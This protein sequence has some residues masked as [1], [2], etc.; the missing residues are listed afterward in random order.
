MDFNGIDYLV[1]SDYYSRWIEID[2][3]SSTTSA[4]IIDK[5]SVYLSREGILLKIRTDNYPTFHVKSNEVIV[6]ENGYSALNIKSDLPKSQ[7]PC[8]ENR[9]HRKKYNLEVSKHKNATSTRSRVPEHAVYGFRSSV[10]L[11][12][13]RQLR[14]ISPCTTKHIKPKTVSSAELHKTRLR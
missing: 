3:M 13:G 10:Q 12:K 8:W 5:L 4:A 1:L 11:H 7:R 9:R 2:K 14:S 6:E